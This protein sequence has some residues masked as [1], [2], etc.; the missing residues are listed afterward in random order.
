MGKPSASPRRRWK[1][2]ASALRHRDG[3]AAD[4]ALGVDLHDLLVAAGPQIQV[5]G[6]SGRLDEYVD[7]AGAGS[8]LQIAEDVAALFTPIAG[9][10]FTLAGDV[11]AQ[12]E[13]VA[14]AGAV[15]VLLQSHSGR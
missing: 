6:K 4:L 3:D 5:G 15:Q 11:A 12:V 1:D 8:A 7:L 9:D 14:V 10:A 2:R 13:F